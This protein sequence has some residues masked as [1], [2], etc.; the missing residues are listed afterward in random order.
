M[1]E[2]TAVLDKGQAGTEE[3]VGNESKEAPKLMSRP[4]SPFKFSL[5]S[6]SRPAT[7]AGD[8]RPLSQVSNRPGSQLSSRRPSNLRWDITGKQK[9]GFQEGLSLQLHQKIPESMLTSKSSSG[10]Q[11]HVPLTLKS[12]H[13]VQSFSHK[14]TA[15]SEENGVKEEQIKMVLDEWKYCHG[16]KDIGIF[17]LFTGHIVVPL[18]VPELMRKYSSME[19]KDFFSSYVGTGIVLHPHAAFDIVVFF[20]DFCAQIFKE[21]DQHVKE[22]E[23]LK[24]MQSIV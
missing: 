10:A 3:D 12:K 15:I 6:G 13:S 18:K 2:K 23:K 22:Q 7:Q 20:W 14:P 4:T 8:S 24:D 9:Q 1:K 11:I 16:R 17:Q 19:E 21:I 5:R